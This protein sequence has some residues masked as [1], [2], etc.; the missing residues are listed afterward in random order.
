MNQD[1]ICT[2]HQKPN[3]ITQQL[4]VLIDTHIQIQGLPLGLDLVSSGLL[5]Q[6]VVGQLRNP[7]TNPFNY[8]TSLATLTYPCSM[9]TPPYHFSIVACPT[10]PQVSDDPKT[11]SQILYRG[12]IPAIRNLPFLKR[13]GLKTVI[14]CRKKEITD[15]DILVRWSQKRGIDL[16]WIKAEGMGEEKLG[17]GKNEISDV[18][19]VSL[20]FV[21]GTG[22]MTDYTESSELPIVYRRPRWDITY[23]TDHRLSTEI[24]RM[25]PRLHHQ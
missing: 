14:Y 20:V 18:L 21:G 23:N 16:R 8:L 6:S 13:L 5:G 12:S 3:S 17:L 11:P 19:K 22:L 7:D 4:R 1:I 25:A 10:T 24:T 9:L 2:F 15:D